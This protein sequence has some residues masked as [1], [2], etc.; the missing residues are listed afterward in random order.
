MPEKTLEVGDMAP[1]FTLMDQNGHPVTLSQFRGKQVILAF[2]PQA[3]TGICTKQMQDL[4]KHR[5]EIQGL[6]AVAL[7]ISVDPIPSKKAWGASMGVTETPLLSDFWPHGKVAQDYG[8]FFDEFG[9]SRRAVFI[10][11]EEGR[12]T[13][14]KVYPT[15]QLPDIEEIL[16]NLEED[17][18]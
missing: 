6:G 17:T 8:V 7:G 12:I 15:K 14:R 9:F 13:W 5:G 3:F 10:V 11:S 1:D 16:E 4:E 18:A 2:H